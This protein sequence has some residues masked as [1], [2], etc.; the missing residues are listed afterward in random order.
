MWSVMRVRQATMKQTHADAAGDRTRRV[1][2]KVEAAHGTMTPLDQ[3][4][5]EVSDEKYGDCHQ[6]YATD[7]SFRSPGVG[8][9]LFG[10]LK[11]LALMK[12]HDPKQQQ[13]QAT[14]RGIWRRLHPITRVSTRSADREASAL[15]MGAPP[16]YG[17]K[18]TT[19]RTTASSSAISF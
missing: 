4:F 11:L 13:P 12:A 8:Y 3:D 15:V 19:R 14:D 17:F 18:A 2:V 5:Q 10:R 9:A 7:A 6:F 1:A 16:R